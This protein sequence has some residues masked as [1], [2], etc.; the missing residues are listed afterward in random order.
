MRKKGK[1]LVFTINGFPGSGKDTFV[2]N[3]AHY[4]KAVGPSGISVMNYST[5]DT[6]KKIY[7]I[8]GWNGVKDGKS[9]KVLSD[10]KQFITEKFG[11]KEIEDKVKSSLYVADMYN[12]SIIIFIH[13]R[14][15]YDIDNIK[16]LV[17]G[18]TV[19]IDRKTDIKELTNDSD[20]HVTNYVYDY[21]IE[22]NSTLDDF[23][24]EAERFAKEVILRELED[25]DE[26]E[27]DIE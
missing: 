12:S 24:L 3:V 14:E 9:R 6:C 7:E 11:Y 16:A 5:I 15:P 25:N 10:L 21:Y 17:G 19:F 2:N 27:G 22:N 20:R 18:E 13:S 1:V 26:S 4:L 23:I 8:C